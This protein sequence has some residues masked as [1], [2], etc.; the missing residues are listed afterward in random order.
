[1][2]VTMMNPIIEVRGLRKTYTQGDHEVHA[3]AGVDLMI[4]PGQFT[5]IMGPSG[6]GKSTMLHLMGGL[7]RPSKG[8]VLYIGG[9]AIQTFVG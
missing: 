6:S 5:S 7:D 3:L 4:Q 1:M 9:Q 8:S 2:G